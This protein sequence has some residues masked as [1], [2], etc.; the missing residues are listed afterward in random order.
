MSKQCDFCGEVFQNKGALGTHKKF[1]DQNPDDTD[2][3]FMQEVFNKRSRKGEYECEDCGE[4]FEDKYKYMGH[5]TSCSGNLVS[6]L[7]DSREKRECPHCKE[8]FRRLDRHLESVSDCKN[9]GRTNCRNSDFCRKRC[10]VKCKGEVEYHPDS[11]EDSPNGSQHTESASLRSESVLMNYPSHSDGHFCPYCCEE[12]D[13]GKSLGAHTVFCLHN[14]QR[15]DTKKKVSEVQKGRNLEDSTKQKI[16]ENIDWNSY[17][18]WYKGDFYH[19]SWEL[20]FAAY[21]YDHHIPFKR[22]RF[23]KFEFKKENGEDGIYIPDFK[24]HDNYYIEV[25]G[26]VKENDYPKINQFP[27]RIELIQRE[28]ITPILDYVERRYGENF[29]ETLYD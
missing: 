6:N 16:S 26:W 28:E 20:A 12:F 13:S 8:D 19:S 18:G 24:Y 15:D 17:Q 3:S 7:P 1:C 14:K 21:H 25:K 11:T 22:V 9:C 5:R 27:H 23:E 4:E 10:E 29:W 2:T